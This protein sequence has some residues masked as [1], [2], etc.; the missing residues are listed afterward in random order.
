M[1][2]EPLDQQYWQASVG[3]VELGMF[4]DADSELAKIDPLIVLRREC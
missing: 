3:Y 4:A 1:P 2:L